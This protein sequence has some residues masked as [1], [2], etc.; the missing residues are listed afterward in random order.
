MEIDNVK[1]KLH[2]IKQKL[3]SIR[4]D[5]KEYEKEFNKWYDNLGSVSKKEA[6]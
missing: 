5:V 3:D 2:G 4:E 6:N 1:L